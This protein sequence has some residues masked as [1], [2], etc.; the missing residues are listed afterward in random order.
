VYDALVGKL[1]DGE[2][3]LVNPSMSRVIARA[4]K[5]PVDVKYMRARV[6]ICISH[7]MAASARTEDGLCERNW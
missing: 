5:C 3:V 6:F 1:R 4:N 7:S 2:D